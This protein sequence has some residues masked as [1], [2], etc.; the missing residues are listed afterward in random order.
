VI[1]RSQWPAERSTRLLY[2]PVEVK[3]NSNRPSDIS[4]EATGDPRRILLGDWS[5][6]TAKGKTD[7]PRP[8]DGN[9]KATAQ[10]GESYPPRPNNHTVAG[11]EDI[12]ESA[13]SSCKTTYACY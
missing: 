4:S 11:A 1:Y 2:S 10:P 7:V 13:D 9:P 5:I 8:S 12:A 6:S 3:R